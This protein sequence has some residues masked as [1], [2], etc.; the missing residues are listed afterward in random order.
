[1]HIKRTVSKETVLFFQYD[2]L[3]FMRLQCTLY[4]QCVPGNH[5]IGLVAFPLH[6]DG[7][8]RQSLPSSQMQ[9]LNCE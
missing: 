6:W 3:H 1:M 8:A 9:S 5:L 4:G 7:S 2:Q